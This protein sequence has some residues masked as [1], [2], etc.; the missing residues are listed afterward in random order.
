MRRGE[1]LLLLIATQIG[2]VEVILVGGA[3]IW[4]CLLHF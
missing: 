1:P 4:Q 3:D 2:S